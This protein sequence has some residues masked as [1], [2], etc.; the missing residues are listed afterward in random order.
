VG[1]IEYGLPNPIGAEPNIILWKANA[2][3]DG[4]RYKLYTVSNNAPERIEVVYMFIQNTSA[5][6]K[7]S[8]VVRLIDLSGAI[9]FSQPT[10]FYDQD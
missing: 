3:Q 6:I 9:L 5:Q 8:F 4:G 10:P 1:G 7:G 2:V